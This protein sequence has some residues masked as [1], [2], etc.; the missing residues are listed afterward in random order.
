MYIYIYSSNI[1]IYITSTYSYG[2]YTSCSSR[3]LH[4]QGFKEK[5]SQDFFYTHRG[6]IMYTKK[7]ELSFEKL[8]LKRK[9]NILK[10]YRNCQFKV[11]L[12]KIVSY[13]AQ[14]YLLYS[15]YVNT[16]L[17]TYLARQGIEQ[18]LPP[19]QTRCDDHAL[20]S[21]SILLLWFNSIRVKWTVSCAKW[22]V[23]LALYGRKYCFWMR[24]R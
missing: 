15:Q 17:L 7:K 3:I 14:L 9:N 10:I 11:K 24:Q 21:N 13:Y 4:K 1:H 23:A 5:P 22:A 16:Y 12:F 20:S 18:I 2:T 6:C 19:K 8:M